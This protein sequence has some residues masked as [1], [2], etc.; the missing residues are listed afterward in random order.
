MVKYRGGF[1]GEKSTRL[2]RQGGAYVDFKHWFKI[3]FLVKKV[4]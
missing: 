4:L 3:C 2:G 1:H